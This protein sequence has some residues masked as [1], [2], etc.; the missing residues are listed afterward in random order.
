MADC[1]L[2]RPA[3]SRLMVALWQF[4]FIGLSGLVGIAIWFPDVLG[5]HGGWIV[6]GLMAFRFALS[7][8]SKRL[9]SNAEAPT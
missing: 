2:P 9:L 6:F 7:R 5:G 4:Y 3:Y 1:Q 8:L